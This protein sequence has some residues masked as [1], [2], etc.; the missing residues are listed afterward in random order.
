[1]TA[2]QAGNPSAAALALLDT[3]ANMTNGFLN[4][5]TLIT[6]PPLHATISAVSVDLP[7]VGELNLVQVPATT[8]TEIP[9]GGLL[10]PLSLPTLNTTLTIPVLGAPLIINGVQVQ[11]S[12]MV[13]GLIPGLQSIAS[14]LATDIT[15]PM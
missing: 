10:T 13:G 5:S 1:M 7:V 2:V 12:T 9:I 4:G 6:L 11:G 15:P 8:T 14:Q 3:P